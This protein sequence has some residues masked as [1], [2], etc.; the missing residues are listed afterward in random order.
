MNAFLSSSNVL[1]TS[2][3]TEA[4]EN[5]K[6]CFAKIP[7]IKASEFDI[8]SGNGTLFLARGTFEVDDKAGVDGLQGKKLLS[9]K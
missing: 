6:L 5:D 3:N 8:L 2:T 1:L 7:K 9:R 4:M